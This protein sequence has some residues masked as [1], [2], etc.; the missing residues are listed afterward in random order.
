MAAERRRISDIP[1][2]NI[3]YDNSAVISVLCQYMAAARLTSRGETS[4]VS[5]A[6]WLIQWDSQGGDDVYRVVKTGRNV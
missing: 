2:A 6:L 5:T 4:G 1:W 3:S